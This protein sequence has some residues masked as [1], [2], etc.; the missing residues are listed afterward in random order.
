MFV[1]RRIGVIAWIAATILSVAASTAAVAA[2]RAQ[3]TD[4]PDVVSLATLRRATSTTTVAA[5][6]VEAGARTAPSDQTGS[7]TVTT[8]SEPSTTT[9]PAIVATPGTTVETTTTTTIAPESDPAPVSA[10]VETR[11]FRGG[12]VTVRLDDGVLILVSAIPDEGYR[13]SIEEQSDGIIALRFVREGR[14]SGYVAQ[15]VD[16]RLQIRVLD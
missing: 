13:L 9:R 2:V 15:I 10:D 11:T 4:R 8:V 1:S 16:G 14:S 6:P 5:L 12:S 7:T 3:V